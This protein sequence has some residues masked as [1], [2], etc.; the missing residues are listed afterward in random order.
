MLISIIFPVFNEEENLK[1]LYE[2]VSEF[3]STLLDY[4]FEFIFVDDFMFISLLFLPD[5]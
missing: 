5:D 3:V 1:L 2:N 4:E